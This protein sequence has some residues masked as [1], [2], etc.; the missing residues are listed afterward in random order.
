MKEKVNAQVHDIITVHTSPPSL[1]FSYQ[2]GDSV[3]SVC[4]NLKTEE[5]S[6]NTLQET[7]KAVS[8]PA[9]S[10]KKNDLKSAIASVFH[11]EQARGYQIIGDN[12]DLHMSAHNKK[13]SLHGS[14]HGSNLPNKH[15]RTLNDV[16]ISGL[17][18]FHNDVE[19]LKK[20]FIGC[21]LE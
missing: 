5:I 18:P 3:K 16:E 7:I 10:L 20:D 6:N 11:Q 21:G 2:P 8:K 19:Q 14:M 1:S 13:E 9:A 4:D 12:V 17:S 15:I